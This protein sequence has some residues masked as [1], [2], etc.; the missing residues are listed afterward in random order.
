VLPH[1]QSTCSKIIQ[2]NALLKEV[3]K[4]VTLQR[5]FLE[6]KKSKLRLLASMR[7]M[8]QILYAGCLGLS[9]AIS[10]QFTVKVNLAVK[11]KKR[12]VLPEPYGP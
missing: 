12:K 10:V 11:R 7:F 6:R 1:G 8:M 9:P 3:L 4:F 5:E 2:C